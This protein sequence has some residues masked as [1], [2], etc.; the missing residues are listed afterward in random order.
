M[1]VR[2][3]FHTLSHYP[4]YEA[5]NVSFEYSSG[6][7]K[8]QKQKC[9]ESLHTSYLSKFSNRKVID[10]STKSTNELGVLL[11]AFNL[12]IFGKKRDFPVE[13]VFQ[14]CKVFENGGPYRDLILKKP[15]DV[16]KDFRLKNSGRLISFDFF[17]N[18]FPNYPRDYF[19]N[20]LYINSL[21]RNTELAKEILQFD[22]FSDIEFNPNKSINCQARAV[23]IFVGLKKCNKL[24][25][26]LKSKETF[27]EVVYGNQKNKPQQMRL[28]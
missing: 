15:K 3:I 22:S 21:Y 19:Y 8:V 25:L 2:P 23:A 24:E 12:K 20:W 28:F 17:G 27:L 10:I 7:S 13:C 4:F 9:L 11:S 16:K 5:I 14:G 18:V 1:A 26:A 6:F